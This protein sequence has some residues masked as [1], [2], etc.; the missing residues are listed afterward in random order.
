MNILVFGATSSIAIAISREYAKQGASLY[1]V[2]RNAEKLEKVRKDLLGYGA[3][4]VTE[5]VC[6]LDNLD[7]VRDRLVPRII[8]GMKLIDLCLLGHGVLGDQNVCEKD[9][10]EAVKVIHTNFLSPVTILTLIAPLLERQRKG[11]IAVLS[12]V[13]GDRGRQSNYVYGSSKAGLDAFLDGLRNRLQA[14]NVKVLVVKPGFVDT[15][16]TSHLKLNP[17]LLASKEKVAKDV[18][19]SV[20]KSQSVCYTPWFW[21]YIM[22]IIRNIPGPI[23]NRLRL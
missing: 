15:P 19:V 12:S 8:E 21:R 22:L 5:Y 4:S 23:F 20:K 9:S 11:T 2:A 1:L 3:V 7:V 14:H 18:I 13:A 10:S 16:M 17:F 6:D